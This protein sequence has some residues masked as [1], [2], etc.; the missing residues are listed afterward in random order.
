MKLPDV[1]CSYSFSRQM[2]AVFLRKYKT[3]LRS[4]S[5]VVSVI[6]PTTFMSI[7][8][9]VVCLAIKNDNLSPSDKTYFDQIKLFVLSY[10]MTWA[11]VFTTS[12]YCGGVVLERE[13][14]FKYLTNVSGT[15]Q[16][17]YWA[18]N[19]AF[20]LL[21]FIVPLTVFFIITFAIG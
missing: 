11:F 4:F 21:I 15:R 16:L 6:M 3:T 18:G 19:Y 7:G 20:D 17:P 5:S 10:F 1:E 8:V 14:R 2:Y 12:S 13:K 9:L